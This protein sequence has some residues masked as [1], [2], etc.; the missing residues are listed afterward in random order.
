[1]FRT[2]AAQRRKQWAAVARDWDKRCQSLLGSEG[3]KKHLRLKRL[4]NLR[5]TPA[6]STADSHLPSSAMYLVADKR[7]REVGLKENLFLA[8][9]LQR[10]V[11]NPSKTK[12]VV[13]SSRRVAAWAWREDG[14]SFLLSFSSFSSSK[15][16]S[17]FELFFLGIKKRLKVESKLYLTAGLVWKC[18]LWELLWFT[19]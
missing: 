17:L 12:V 18:F 6:G 19:C 3:C 11:P 9:R 10:V 13:G 14:E 7:W 1:M 16:L 4:Q 2:A 8:L 15:V 5:P